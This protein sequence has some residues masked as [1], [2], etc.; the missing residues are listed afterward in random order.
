MNGFKRNAYPGWDD[1]WLPRYYKGFGDYVDL[2]ALTN[3]IK[4]L[5]ED[6]Y[7][8]KHNPADALVHH[9]SWGTVGPAAY[10]SQLS[11]WAAAGLDQ[12]GMTSYN[13][14]DPRRGGRAPD[15]KYGSNAPQPIVSGTAPGATAAQDI[16]FASPAQPDYGGFLSASQNPLRP[17]SW[18]TGLA[19]NK[20]ST[21]S[22]IA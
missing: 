7:L 15:Y 17:G 19:E 9:L 20:N 8:T 4:N 21:Y 6:I 18:P 11:G 3:P 1:G 14:T 10:P 12:T 22:G 2:S 13:Y 5:K 16:N